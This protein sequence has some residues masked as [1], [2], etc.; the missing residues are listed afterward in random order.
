MRS[1]AKEYLPLPDAHFTAS[2]LYLLPTRA[3]LLGSAVPWGRAVWEPTVSSTGQPCPLPTAAAPA[4]PQILT[5]GG[6]NPA[7]WRRSETARGLSMVGKADSQE[8]WQVC[9]SEQGCVQP[10]HPRRALTP[11]Q[12]QPF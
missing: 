10:Q 3:P 11:P 9:V 2:L 7:Q 1:K 6:V 4:A 8:R 12:A 5:P